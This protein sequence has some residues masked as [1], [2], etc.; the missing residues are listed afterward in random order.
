MFDSFDSFLRNPSH[1]AT[2]KEML[3]Y[4]FL[5]DEEAKC[6]YDGEFMVEEFMTYV[7]VE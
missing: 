6:S 7:E 1:G 2:Q 3:C 5:N 4:R